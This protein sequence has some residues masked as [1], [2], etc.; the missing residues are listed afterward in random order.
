MEVQPLRLPKTVPTAPSPALPLAGGGASVE[1]D[2]T[3]DAD[4]LT[5]RFLDL[6][7]EAFDENG[8]TASK[9]PQEELRSVWQQALYRQSVLEAELERLRDENAELRREGGTRAPP[10]ESR[11]DDDTPLGAWDRHAGSAQNV[12]G[13]LPVYRPGALS[14]EGPLRVDWMRSCGLGW[15]D[16]TSCLG[17]LDARLRHA[18]VA[19][20]PLLSRL[21]STPLLCRETARERAHDLL[22]K[23][24][25]LL[26]LRDGQHNA[27]ATLPA[28][29]RML[30]AELAEE[31]IR[32]HGLA[33]SVPAIFASEIRDLEGQL[34]HARG[35]AEAQYATLRQL[36][37]ARDDHRHD[38]FVLL[39]ELSKALGRAS[40]AQAT[41]GV[42][43]GD[44][45]EGALADAEA[46]MRA[47]E[48]RLRQPLEVLLSREDDHRQP[49][50]ALDQVGAIVSREWDE[51]VS[52]VRGLFGKRDD[53]AP[54]GKRLPR[55]SS[56]SLQSL[57]R[58]GAPR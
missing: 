16:V 11:A 10:L 52:R 2:G 48:A 13:A 44:A 28:I 39:D 47:A 7:D 30:G 29:G 27:I 19:A 32:A 21:M 35:C 1:A 49:S 53:N 25:S 4:A 17:W 38:V 12:L 31:E 45:A 56:W 54:R 3:S 23:R 43:D 20:F 42:G 51:A 37:D 50:T 40:A 57:R 14:P 33:H 34:A 22:Q 41:G 26:L 18:I 24:D 15:N 46:A 55:S 36:R 5:P 8:G 9:D 58:G 6:L